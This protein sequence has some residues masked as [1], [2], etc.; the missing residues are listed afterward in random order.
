[1]LMKLKIFSKSYHN[2]IF[3]ASSSINDKIFCFMKRFFAVMLE[4]FFDMNNFFDILKILKL[5][6]ANDTAS[7]DH[8]DHSLGAT[9][10]QQPYN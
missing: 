1:M 7:V 5:I 9:I 4:N 2:I 8:V 10:S 3:F 6:F